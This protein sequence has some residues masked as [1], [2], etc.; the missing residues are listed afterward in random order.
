MCREVFEVF[1]CPLDL[2]P[3]VWGRDRLAQAAVWH[4]LVLPVFP[5]WLPRP[6]RGLVCLG[7]SE[8]GEGLLSSIFPDPP[9]R[10]LESTAQSQRARASAQQSLCFF[11]L[12][13]KG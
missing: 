4:L 8:T 6:P 3:G 11:F 7:S 5:I 9:R 12:K 1:V 10:S 2:D 13:M